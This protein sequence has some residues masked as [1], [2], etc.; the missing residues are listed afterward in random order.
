MPFTLAEGLDY[1]VAAKVQNF[2]VEMPMGS[3]TEYDDVRLTDFDVILARSDV[4]ISRPVRMNYDNIFSV[5]AL[6]IEVLRGYVAVDATVAGI[7]YRIVNTHLESF[8][9]DVRVV[10]VARHRN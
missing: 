9:K 4:T 1:Q 2:D 10:Q 8:A 5:E 3:F 7:T 6:F